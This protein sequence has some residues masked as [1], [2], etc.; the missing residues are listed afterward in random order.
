MLIFRV[1]FL[2]V[3]SSV[4]SGGISTFNH[5]SGD[6]SR[7]RLRL[8]QTPILRDVN[9]DGKF[10]ATRKRAFLLN[11]LEADTLSLLIHLYFPSK[12]TDITVD[13]LVELP[14]KHSVKMRSLFSEQEIFHRAKQLPRKDITTSVVIF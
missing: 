5:L 4:K 9:P 12:V 6:W 14:E 13:K 11:L 7:F 8:E 1:L 2:L 3:L 10:D